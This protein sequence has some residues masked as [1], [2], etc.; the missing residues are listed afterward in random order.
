M[1]HLTDA[2]KYKLGSILLSL[3][4]S[5]VCTDLARGITVDI[6]LNIFESL[7]EAA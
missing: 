4:S 6:N 2:E 7:K 3:P 1:D 5:A